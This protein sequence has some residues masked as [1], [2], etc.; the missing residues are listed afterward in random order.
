[1]SFEEYSGNFRKIWETIRELIGKNQNK[2]FIPDFFRDG[3]DIIKGDKNI[4]NG[5]NDFFSSI[6]PELASKIPNSDNQYS[7][8]LGNKTDSNFIVCQVTPR[9]IS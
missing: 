3:E 9:L 1:M 2:M 7:S 5:F 4:A 8:F 6:G